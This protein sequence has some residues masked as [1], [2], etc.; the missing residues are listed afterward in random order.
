MDSYIGR[1][2]DNR[3]EILENI[4]SG[5][6]AEVYKALDHRLNRL[7]AVKILKEEL[8][9]NQEFRRRFQTESQAVAMLSHPNIVSVYD[10]SSSGGVDYIV[11][12][13]IEGI[14]LKQYME[15]K[16]PLNWRE[17]LHFSMQIAK[18]LEHAHGRGIVHRDIKPHNI[19]ILK[20]GSIKVTDFGIA[21]IGTAQNTLTREALGSVHYIS[22]EQAKG[23]MVDNRSDIYS[24]GI[25][26]YEML[27]GRP[28]YD[29][30]TPVSV[31]IQ[32]INGGARLPS[33]L[34]TGIPLGLEQ[35]TMHAMNCNVEARYSSATEMLR[36]MEEFRKNPS[37]TFHFGNTGALPLIYGGQEAPKSHAVPQQ[38]PVRPAAPRPNP[39]QRSAG[40]MS[41]SEAERY[42]AARSAGA[43]QRPARGADGRTAEERRA[44]RARREREQEEQKR[45][46]TMTIA[47]IAA[48]VVVVL[49]TVLIVVLATGSSNPGDTSISEEEGDIRVPNFVG[50]KLEDLNPDD[51]P[52]LKLDLSDITYE[53]SDKY[54][55]GYIIAQTPKA[56]KKVR[57]GRTVKF[58]VSKGLEEN[59][60]PD[61]TDQLSD[62]AV[63]RLND[64]NLN[65]NIRIEEEASDKV[66]KGYVV[67]T[68]PVSGTKLSK[69][70]T[71]TVYVSLGSNK[72]PNLVKESKEN[73]RKRLEAMDLNLN[74]LFLEEASQDIDKDK[75]IR[76]EPS[77]DATLSKGQ[78]VTVYVST[79]DDRIKVPDVRGKSLDTAMTLLKNAG[80]D[81]NNIKVKESYD[82]SVSE[83]HIIEQSIKAD[84]M[85][86]KDSEIEIT[87]C[88]APPTTQPTTQPTT[89]PDTTE[90]TVEPTP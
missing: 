60:M 45:R 10:V 69:S 2:L 73:A 77:A 55:E 81:T 64:M 42:A 18:A 25:V 38:E 8:S 3:Y 34:V 5:G 75:V 50:E 47:I 15:R 58:T 20:D 52:D 26:M 59:T 48:S 71:V 1:L 63:K 37:V 90:P 16:G 76:T 46:R 85:V 17:T 31:A 7:V 9:R 14:S 28:P 66:T 49:L 65:L 62:D 40:G 13:L 74:I 21:R 12:E 35:I 51:Y 67:R 54:E 30:E 79:G 53:F 57:A 86:D 83:G 87:V 61:V 39:Q 82:S 78:T 6:M 56:D 32:H 70:Q 4:G 84:K 11:M 33:E 88:T 80:F 68:E 43:A 36:D 19:L 44:A 89:P 41:R 72:M 29:G 22:P 23:A 27:T 24:L